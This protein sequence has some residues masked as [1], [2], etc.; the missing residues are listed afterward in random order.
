MLSVHGGSDPRN[1]P[2]GSAWPPPLLLAA[3]AAM[4]LAG[5]ADRSLAVLCFA[6]VVV[7]LITPRPLMLVAAH[8]ASHP[9]P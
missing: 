2:C 5:F 4:L 3:T 7:A 1:D 8:P 6:A 9:A